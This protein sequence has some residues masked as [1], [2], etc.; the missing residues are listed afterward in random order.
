MVELPTGT[1]TFLFTDIEGSTRLIL[2]LGDEY[3]AVLETHARVLRDAIARQ[4]GTEVSTEGDSF[5][6]VFD[7]APAAVQAA[8]EAQRMLGTQR[9]PPGASVRVRMGLHT[10]QGVL[11][12]DNYVGLD[13]HRGARI[14]GAGHG[15]QVLLSAAVRDDLGVQ[16]PPQISLRDL[17]LHRLK[18]LPEPERL[19]QA[20]AADLPAD[21]PPL[22]SMEARPHNLPSELSEFVGRVDEADAIERLLE[23]AR[24]VTLIGPGGA[25]KTRL[26][27]KVAARVLTRFTDGVFF[28]PLWS[29]RDQELVVPTIASELGVADAGDRSLLDALTDHLSRKQLLLVIDNF[30]QVLPAAPTLGHLLEAAPDL[31]ILATSRTLL[32]VGGE[33]T[34]MVPPLALPPADQTDV[35]G[36]LES[37]VVSLFVRRARSADPSFTPTAENIQAIGEIAASLDGLPLAIE[38]AAA[39]VRLFTPRQLLQKLRDRPD[40]LRTDSAHVPERQQTLAGSIA[41]SYRLLDGSDRAALR[42]LSAFA[43]GFTLESAEE[44]AQGAPVRDVIEA[45]S[46]RCWTTASSSIW[47]SPTNGGSRC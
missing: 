8:I 4:G 19:Y 10:G 17:G 40:L 24:L 33:Q 26:A 5:F 31:R 1:V 28:V 35:G 22:R 9:W 45:P 46:P 27:L 20:Q 7:V 23:E 34:F 47:S 41:W 37:D 11:G 13:V 14:A 25:G 42:R 18:D 29:E 12:G 15:G 2:R 32:R 43:G 30:E 21:F 36:A 39:R 38:L 3:P 16:L 44:V 6:A